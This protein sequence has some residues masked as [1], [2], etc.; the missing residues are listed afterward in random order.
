[1]AQAASPWRPR[2]RREEYAPEGW[3]R[4]VRGLRKVAEP[5]TSL[6]LPQKLVASAE[7]RARVAQW[8]GAVA[9]A[10]ERWRR[11]GP[12]RRWRSPRAF[13]GKRR[14]DNQ[15]FDLKPKRH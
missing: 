10:T 12:L 7:P 2:L 3:A 9:G 15:P 8:L 1:M 5:G 11:R 13:D 14:P 4:A 6:M